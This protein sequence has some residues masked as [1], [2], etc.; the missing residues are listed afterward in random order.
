[1]RSHNYSSVEPSVDKGRLSLGVKEDT[2][3]KVKSPD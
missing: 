3:T 2:A 1:M